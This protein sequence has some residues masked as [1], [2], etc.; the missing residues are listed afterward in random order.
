MPIRI[1]LSRRFQKDLEDLPE[2][3]RE[4]LQDLI[5][6]FEAGK[7]VDITK[8]GKQIWR[9]KIPNWRAFFRFR[10]EDAEFLYI[11]RRTTTTYRKR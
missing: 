5:E 6:D 7:K 9:L 3:D 10:K 8:L 2:K 11:E 1:V 4:A